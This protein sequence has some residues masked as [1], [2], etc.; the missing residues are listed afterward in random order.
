MNI[1]LKF[2]VNKNVF[3][4][5]G[6]E[7]LPRYF[8]LVEHAKLHGDRATSLWKPSG[9]QES[10]LQPLGD[11]VIFSRKMPIQRHS[12]QISLIFKAI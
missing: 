5:Q 3:F 9:S 2:F 7:L 11:L 8:S 4:K 1:K 12:D 10:N 6:A